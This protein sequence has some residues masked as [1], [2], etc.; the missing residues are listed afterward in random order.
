M[1]EEIRQKVSQGTVLLVPMLETQ[2]VD[3]KRYKTAESA[4]CP[5]CFKEIGVKEFE[6]TK[7]YTCRSC[8]TDLFFCFWAEV[9]GKSKATLL[10]LQ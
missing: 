9:K 4:S 6:H 3:G 8:K 1:V 10:P 7:K 2:K 5:A